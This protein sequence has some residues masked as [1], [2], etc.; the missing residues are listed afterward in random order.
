M[1]ITSDHVL[2]DTVCLTTCTPWHMHNLMHIGCA[3]GE[4]ETYEKNQA[5]PK[6]AQQATL[7]VPGE[8]VLTAKL[9]TF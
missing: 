5:P 8:R 9:P 1:V 2:G 4:V 7:Q 6:I 3:R